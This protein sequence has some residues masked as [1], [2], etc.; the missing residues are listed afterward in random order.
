MAHQAGDV[1]AQL[2]AV[3][4]AA[5]LP[6]FSADHYAKMAALATKGEA[7]AWLCYSTGPTGQCRALLCYRFSCCPPQSVAGRPFQHIF[8]IPGSM[9][10]GPMQWRPTAARRSSPPCTARRCRR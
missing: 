6:S 9:R 7:G 1:P 4:R 3:G 2:A 8:K 10:V 5:A